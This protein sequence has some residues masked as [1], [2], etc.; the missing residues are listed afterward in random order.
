MTL[1]LVFQEAVR[2]VVREEIRAAL[3]EHRGGTG[4]EEIL[5]YSQGAQL[6]GRHVSTIVKWVHD[7]LLPA[8]GRGKGRRV[9]RADVL[10]ALELSSKPRDEATSAKEIAD[11]ILAGNK[12]RR[13]R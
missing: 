9:Y 12:V 6:I 4:G 13:I 1:D 8:H 7:G 11:N 2:T 10:R 5:T 3:A